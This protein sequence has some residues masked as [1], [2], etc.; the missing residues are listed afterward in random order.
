MT[1]KCH[2]P[3]ARVSVRQSAAQ[4]SL[5]SCLGHWLAT[6]A[7]TLPPQFPPSPCLCLSVCLFSAS[8]YKTGCSDPPF[9][10]TLPFLSVALRH[11]ACM[12]LVQTGGI[13]VDKAA[14]LQKTHQLMSLLCSFRK[15]SAQPKNKDCRPWQR[16][17]RMLHIPQVPNK[18]YI[19]SN[20]SRQDP[21]S[22]TAAMTVLWWMIANTKHKSRLWVDAVVTHAL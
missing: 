7:V 2:Q 3:A 14:G 9:L 5:S 22:L 18:N 21:C 20:H 17:W 6:L 10:A 8:L 15:I 19:S 11:S 4:S 16:P 13:A 1:I 12:V